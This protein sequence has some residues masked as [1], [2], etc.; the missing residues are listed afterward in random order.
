MSLPD[1]E[2]KDYFES[3]Q[4]EIEDESLEQIAVIAKKD[5]GGTSATFA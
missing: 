4:D 2:G 1:Y 5:Q 3:D